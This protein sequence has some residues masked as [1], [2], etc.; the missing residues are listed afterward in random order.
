M[1]V[2]YI[3]LALSAVLALGYFVYNRWFFDDYQL[4]RNFQI[5]KQVLDAHD[6]KFQALQPAPAPT[7]AATPAQ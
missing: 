3:Q 6:K 2:L 5:I 1:K 7:A 4:D